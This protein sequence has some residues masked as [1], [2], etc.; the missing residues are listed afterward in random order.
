MIRRRLATALSVLL[1]TTV[2]GCSTPPRIEGTRPVNTAIGDAIDEAIPVL[3]EHD[4]AS[5]ARW[6]AWRVRH[7]RPLVHELRGDAEHPMMLTLVPGTFTATAYAAPVLEATR[8]EDAD[9]RRPILGTPDPAIPAD[10]LPTRRELAEDPS[11]RPDVLGWVADALDAYL[12]EV[13]GSVALRFPDGEVLCLRWSRTNERPYTSLGRRLV[14]EGLADPAT[15]D[16]GVIRARHRRDPATVERLMLDNDRVV[17][18]EPVPADRWPRASTGG[19]L[20]PRHAVAVDPDVIPLGSVVVVEGPNVER[21]VAVAI[22]IGGAITGRRIDLYL[23]AGDAA[24][25]EAGAFIE[26]VTVSILVPAN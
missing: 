17:F 4:P 12:A 2:G 10:A 14:E 25:A 1:A 9:H 18:F 6:R 26:D 5:A 23:G 7:P 16:L 3:A 19:R 21:R 13:N 15:I 11:R 8:T 20:I 22:D 24:L